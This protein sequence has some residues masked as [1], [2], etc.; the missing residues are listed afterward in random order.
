MS[1]RNESAPR[2][3]DS[4]RTNTAPSSS[5]TAEPSA[6]ASARAQENPQDETDSAQSSETRPR[7]KTEDPDR[8]L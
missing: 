1:D 5:E 4:T 7:G 2:A 8:T 6:G 3:D